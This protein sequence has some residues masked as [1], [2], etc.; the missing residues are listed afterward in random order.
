MSRF[1]AAGGASSGSESS[2]DDSSDYSSDASGG[3]GGGD[4]GGGGGGND[5]KWQEL[6]DDSSSDDE[7]RVA[8]SGKERALESFQ[9]HIANLRTAMKKKDYYAL[10]QEFDALAKSM[11]KAKAVLAKGVP[12]P[13]VRILCDLEDYVPARLADKA[14]F[15]KLS[16]R[17]GRSLN[18]MK[19]TLK[20]HN[21]PY[22]VVMKQY[23]ANPVVSDSDD[24][25]SSD[26]DDDDDDD[27]KEN[28]DSDSDDD[29]DDSDAKKKTTKKAA[30]V[31][32]DDSDSD[33]SSANCLKDPPQVML[34]LLLSQG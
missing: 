13:L 23:R 24:S 8:K 3:D 31:D 2:D 1:W 28:S 20:K 9:K 5:N 10:Q 11:I 17:Q 16:A 29:S 18:R 25:D 4:G 33:V 34:L 21:K 15:K 22:A 30:A 19:L 14:A 12:R 27:D 6:S 26:D 32:S 7:V